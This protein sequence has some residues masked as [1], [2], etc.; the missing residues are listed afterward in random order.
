MC[1][2]FLETFG[3]LLFYIKHFVVYFP[4]FKLK[5]MALGQPFLGPTSHA[6]SFVTFAIINVTSL[7]LKKIYDIIYNRYF[8]S[9]MDLFYTL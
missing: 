6:K 5:C 1:P 3:S 2:L 9:D 8:V 7:L 4:Q